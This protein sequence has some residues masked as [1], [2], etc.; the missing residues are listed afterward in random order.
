MAEIEYEGIKVGGSKLLLLIPLLGTLGGGLWGGFEFYKDYMDMKEIIANIDTQA[1]AARNDVIET[2]LGEAIDYT[3]D[4]KNDLRTDVMAM[5]DLVD[6][7][8][9]KTEEAV[10]RVEIRMDTAEDRIKNANAAIEETL[11]G[12]RNEMNTLQ[13]DVTASI[14]EIEASGRANEKDVR[15]TMRA[16][17]TR[18]DEKMRLLERDLKEILQEALDNPLANN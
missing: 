13:K 4:I 18:L 3:R 11:E 7:I 8:E 15:D 2:K 16:T 6:R 12:V 9:L 14:R 17:E 10:T 5:E 1:I